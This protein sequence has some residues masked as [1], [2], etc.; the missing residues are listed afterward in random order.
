M[1]FVPFS[2][3]HHRNERPVQTTVLQSGADK[4][5]EEEDWNFEQVCLDPLQ[6]VAIGNASC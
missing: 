5:Q 1:A 6:S 4:V 3:L 2:D